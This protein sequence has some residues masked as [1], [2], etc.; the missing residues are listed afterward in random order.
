MSDTESYFVSPA[1]SL[2]IL[3]I[4]TWASLS[5]LSTYPCTER[6]P[7]ASLR[8]PTIFYS[9]VFMWFHCQLWLVLVCFIVGSSIWR[10]W[11]WHWREHSD[12]SCGRVHRYSFLYVPAGTSSSTNTFNFRFSVLASSSWQ[13]YQDLVDQRLS[14]NLSTGVSNSNFQLHCFSLQ[15]I[16][17]F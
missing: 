8:A 12:E 1:V 14:L 17:Y 3:M 15:Q 11:T 13:W 9:F 6:N 4:Q 10:N 16:R 2:I 5:Y 7:L